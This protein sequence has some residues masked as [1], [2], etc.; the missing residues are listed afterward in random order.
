V[1]PN[2]QLEILGQHEED[3]NFPVTK[4]GISHCKRF[5]ASLSHDSSIKFYDIS[6]FVASRGNANS[7][8]WE[9]YESGEE[10]VATK[11]GKKTKKDD[12]MESEGDFEDESDS[13]DDD[14]SEEIGEEKKKNT[15]K[16][17][18][19]MDDEEDDDDDED[20]SDDDGKD[21][22]KKNKQL[23]NEKR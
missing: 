8:M 2:K 19:E 18:D 21:K 3:E 6:S 12:E 15:N 13:D 20:D 23:K 14:D 9:G 16:G 17:D 11:G 1:Y 10:I 22:K 5:A 7:N 4:L